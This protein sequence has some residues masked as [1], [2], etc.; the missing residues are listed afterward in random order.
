MWCVRVVIFTSR[1]RHTGGAGVSWERRCVRE[2]RREKREER[3]EKREW[4]GGFSSLEVTSLPVGGKWDGFSYTFD[5][6]D[7]LPCVDVGR[8]RSL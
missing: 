7:D 4:P 3:R 5:A 8:W 6:V 1:R 2:T